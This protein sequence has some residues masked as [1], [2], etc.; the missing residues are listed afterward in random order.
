MN[1]LANSSPIS[2]EKPSLKQLQMALLKFLL[3]NP[4]EVELIFCHGNLA[5]AASYCS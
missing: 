5:S 1:R 2:S 4:A 3:V